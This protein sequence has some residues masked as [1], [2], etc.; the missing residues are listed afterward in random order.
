MHLEMRHSLRQTLELRPPLGVDCPPDPVRGF[1]GMAAAHSICKRLG[2]AGLLIGGIARKAWTGKHRGAISPRKDVDVIVLSSDEKYH[3]KRF[4][5]GIDWWL[6]NEEWHLV[7]GNDCVL[8]YSVIPLVALEPGLHIATPDML[9]MWRQ[10]EK[11]TFTDKNV[12]DA[13]PKKFH[14][15]P[16][17]HEYPVIT[18]SSCVTGFIKSETT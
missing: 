14:R 17:I 2:V 5:G 7:N 13:F 12:R 15:K 6:P 18:R 4:E 9:Y 1:N 3:P 11:V 8:I 16:I 10:R